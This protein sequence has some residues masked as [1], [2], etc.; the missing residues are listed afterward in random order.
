MPD[1]CTTPT[2][3]RLAGYAEVLFLDFSWACPKKP[4]DLAEL[5]LYN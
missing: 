4:I 2:P 5:S 3:N 1:R